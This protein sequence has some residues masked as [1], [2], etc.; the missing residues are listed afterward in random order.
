M[1][2]LLPWHATPFEK[3]FSRAA[4]PAVRLDTPVTISRGIK[5]IG[6]PPS[7]LPF[8]IHEYGLGELSP[9]VPNLYKLIDDGIRWQRVRGTPA[10]ISRGLGWL[11]YTGAIEEAEIRR[12]RWHLF[13]LQLGRV[14]DNEEPDLDRIEGV[15]Q[16]SVPLRSQF[17]RGFRTHDVRAMEYAWKR[18]SS[19][20]Y[21]TH[22]GARI[23]P[24]GAK[25]SFGRVHELD[26][27]LTQA[28]LT[29]L[30]VWVASVPPP[31]VSTWSATPWPAAPWS[32]VGIQIRRDAIIGNLAAMSA[33]IT[34]LTAAGAVIGHRRARVWRRVTSGGAA[35]P[36]E[37]SA[38]KLDPLSPGAA[39]ASALYVEAQTDF[40]DG[41][42][43]TAA[44]W[45]VRLGA[46]LADPA[47]PG[48]LWAEPSEL[49]GGTVA[50]E[51]TGTIQFGRTVRERC[52]AV[53]RV[54]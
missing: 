32:D 25:W 2:D 43:Q 41:Y 20:M 53:L 3:A 9:Y 48:L 33:W 44:R 27:T 47:R 52:R 7:W 29:A 8:L 38:S 5:Y 14:R 21:A 16:L 42:G 34:F 28:P 45:Q 54:V 4:D 11:G 6:T 40:G 37:V 19:A 30:G 36:Y 13:Q 23:R 35:S 1:P 10:A 46:T 39:G 17:W 18:H 24:G 51:R 31:T 26:H 15:T 49:T 50:A 12:T 22:S